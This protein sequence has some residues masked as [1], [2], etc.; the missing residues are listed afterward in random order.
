LHHLVDLHEIGFGR[1]GHPGNE[2]GE[3]LGVERR[4][5]FRR[6]VGVRLV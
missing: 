2:V 5:L 1:H 6:F 4:E 3:S